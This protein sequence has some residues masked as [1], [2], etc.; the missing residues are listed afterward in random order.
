MFNLQVMF[1][2]DPLHLPLWAYI[3]THESRLL[4]FWFSYSKNY[5]GVFFYALFMLHLFLGIN[6]VYWVKN[7]RNVQKTQ[8]ANYLRSVKWLA[9]SQA[10]K[11]GYTANSTVLFQVLQLYS[12]D[13]TSY[14]QRL[15]V[16]YI[17]SCQCFCHQATLSQLSYI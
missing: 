2:S 13:E 14:K 3:T 5:L 4:D 8:C 9:C 15:A 16:S 1:S 11:K 12:I 7:H 6:K 17:L 10:A